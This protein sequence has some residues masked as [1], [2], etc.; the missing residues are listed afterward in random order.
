MTDV[1]R[2]FCMGN[3]LIVGIPHLIGKAIVNRMNN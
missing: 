3:V 1:N 2:A